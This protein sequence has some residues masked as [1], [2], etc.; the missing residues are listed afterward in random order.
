MRYV[1]EKIQNAKKD[2]YACSLKFC[3]IIKPIKE[4]VTENDINM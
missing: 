4:S 1:S 2:I 3:S